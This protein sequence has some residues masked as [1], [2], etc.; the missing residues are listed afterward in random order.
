MSARA[1]GRA[2]PGGRLE[3]SSA[4]LPVTNF[5]YNP[6]GVG[7]PAV[8]MSGAIMPGSMRGNGPAA[9]ASTVSN[10]LASVWGG[11]DDN[12]NEHA[13][14]SNWHDIHGRHNGRT[15]VAE[16]RRLTEEI[17]N[18]R[19]N[20]FLALVAPVLQTNEMYITISRKEPYI[21]P[22]DNIPMQ[23]T[24]YESITVAAQ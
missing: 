11:G 19:G 24:P 23:G 6:K 20:F 10:I 15:L 12:K 3:R 8:N 9:P 14:L 7:R 4:D 22:L 5:R 17:I 18:A 13:Y 1:P 21:M 2:L 16:S